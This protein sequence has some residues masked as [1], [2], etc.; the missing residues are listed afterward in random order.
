MRHLYR[1]GSASNPEELIAHL[2]RF[3]L[4][5]RVIPDWLVQDPCRTEVILNRPWDGKM[6]TPLVEGRGPGFLAPDSPY[7]T[8][9]IAG[10]GISE[11]L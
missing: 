5:W 10:T 9:S 8:R 4:K 6:E 2:D 3:W 1:W 7:R 11:Q